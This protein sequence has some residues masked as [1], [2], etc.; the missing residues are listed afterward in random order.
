MTARDDLGF[1]NHPV[2]THTVYSVL[3]L[4]WLAAPDECLTVCNFAL[5]NPVFSGGSRPLLRRKHV[6]RLLHLNLSLPMQRHDFSSRPHRGRER[7]K[8]QSCGSSVHFDVVFFSPVEHFSLIEGALLIKNLPPTLSVTSFNLSDTV[9][10]E[11]FMT[12]AANSWDLSFKKKSKQLLWKLFKR[13]F[14]F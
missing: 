9:F 5:L 10:K 6:L 1:L 3:Y 4:L 11:H 7:K 12:G 8:M 14:F 2:A 13:L